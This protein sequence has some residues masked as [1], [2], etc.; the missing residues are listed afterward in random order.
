MDEKMLRAHLTKMANENP[1]MRR[2][3][4]PLLQGKTAG[5]PLMPL[6]MRYQKAIAELQRFCQHQMSACGTR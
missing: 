6:G 2:H 4:L 3:L 5:G 1:E